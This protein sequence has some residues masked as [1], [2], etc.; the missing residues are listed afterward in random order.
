MSWS[1]SF[2]NSKVEQQTW[3]LPPSVLANFLRIADLIEEFGPDLGRP[4]TAPLGNGLFEIRVKGREGIARALFC[5][6]PGQEIVILITVIK[7]DRT[8]PKRH[9]ETARR[10]MKAV[11]SD[12]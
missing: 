9:E 12:D 7:K 6:L 3:K 5:H 10:R 8:L 11:L 1:I 4:Y 2:Y